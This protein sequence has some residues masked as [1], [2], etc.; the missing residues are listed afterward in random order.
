MLTLATCMLLLL[1]SASA[2]GPPSP[3]PTPCKHRAPSRKAT[4][5][6]KPLLSARIAAHEEATDPHREASDNWPR[7]DEYE[8][9]FYAFLEARGPASDEAVAALLGIYVGEH[10]GE[11]LMCEAF[12][13]GA[14][15]VPYLKRFRAC[16]PLTALGPIPP[17]LFAITDHRGEALALITN[18][19]SP[20]P[21]E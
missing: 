1:P 18:K 9:A 10:M 5:F 15:I 21:E 14:R 16:E 8:T 20:C 2:L 7:A 13:R 17:A 6:L 3:A 19:Q 11:E 4:E 12:Q